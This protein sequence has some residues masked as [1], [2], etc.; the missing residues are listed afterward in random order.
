MLAPSY[1]SFLKARGVSEKSWKRAKRDIYLSHLLNLHLPT[2]RDMNELDDAPS[3]L[4][5]LNWAR[6]A[7]NDYVHEGM[8]GDDVTPEAVSAAIGTAEA[9][10]AFLRRSAA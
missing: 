2:M 1:H 7:R 8:L 9:L 3:I 6:K 10:I 5:R 4:A